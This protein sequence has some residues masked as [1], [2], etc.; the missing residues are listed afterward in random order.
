MLKGKSFFFL[1]LY[2][3]L[4][5]LSRERPINHRS[6]DRRARVFQSIIFLLLLLINRSDNVSANTIR[7]CLACAGAGAEWTLNG[8]HDCYNHTCWA[9][10]KDKKSHC[11]R[12][13]LSENGGRCY[14]TYLTGCSWPFEPTFEGCMPL[15]THMANIDPNSHRHA[16]GWRNGERKGGGCDGSFDWG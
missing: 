5:M 8:L 13:I 14:D 4:A 6:L 1:V 2:F 10:T 7:K 16:P 3:Y 9:D 11:V 12:L 15:K